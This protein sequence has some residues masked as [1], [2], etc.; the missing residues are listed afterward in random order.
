MPEKAIGLVLEKHKKSLL[1]IAG[2]VGVA[3][4]ESNGKPCIRVFATTKDNKLLGQ[5]P[6]SLEG[7]EVIVDKTG[8][9]RAL[10]T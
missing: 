8:E 7:Y 2:V 9:I 10:N 3:V 5:I 6:H 4:G 1:S